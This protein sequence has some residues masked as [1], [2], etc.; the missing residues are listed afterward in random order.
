LTADDP[1]DGAFDIDIDEG[2]AETADSE[3][4]GASLTADDSDDGAFDID[5]DEGLAE[6]A[7]DTDDS[8]PM[9]AEPETADIAFDPFG[10]LPDDDTVTDDDTEAEAAGGQ[11]ESLLAEAPA[12]ELLVEDISDSAVA[13]SNAAA[14]DAVAN[15]AVADEALVEEDSF[16]NDFSGVED[17]AFDDLGDSVAASL[18][19]E[20]PETDAEPVGAD[21]AKSDEAANVEADPVLSSLHD[22]DFRPLAPIPEDTSYLDDEKPVEFDESAP[23]PLEEALV[24]I[25]EKKPAPPRVP[26]DEGDPALQ[27]VPQRFKQELRTVLSYMDILL[28]SLPEEKIEE[29]A[30][31]EHFEPYK[32]LF[33]ELGLA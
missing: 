17:S 3:E 19:P 30:R 24:P 6:T 25:P 15:N 26:A 28:E 16:F 9:A 5:I 14:S 31:S 8:E 21:R 18:T 12:D 22:E 27:G 2:L 33:K 4:A 7:D 23:E 20:T 1:D 11:E 10:S 29:F 32:K 13:A